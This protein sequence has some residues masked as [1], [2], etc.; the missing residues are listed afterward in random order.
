MLKESS[1]WNQWS[2]SSFITFNCVA[3]NNINL[4]LFFHN[5]TMSLHSYSSNSSYRIRKN[6][7]VLNGSINPYSSIRIY[8]SHKLPL[9]DFFTIF[10][11]YDGY[12]CLLQMFIEYILSS[13]KDN[14]F[15][16]LNCLS[17]YWK[18]ISIRG[19]L[20]KQSLFFSLFA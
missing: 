12:Y 17:F 3:H 8:F 14:Q 18:C 10:Y 6:V 4:K 13:Y 19:F 2:K 11:T 16:K 15:S 1:I 5:V 20:N 7:S 9:S